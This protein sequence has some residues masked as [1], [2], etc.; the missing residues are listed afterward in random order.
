[1]ASQLTEYER[2]RLE[3]IKRN[4][5][6]MA[7]LKIQSR[8]SELSSTKRKRAE[9]SKSYK[10]NP[11]KKEE[12]VVIRRSLRTRGM[13]P[14]SKGL[15]AD[16][17][18]SSIKISKPVYTPISS[19]RV[20]GPLRFRDSCSHDSKSDVE[21]FT[22]SILSI[23]NGSSIGE[24]SGAGIRNMKSSRQGKSDSNSCKFELESLSLEPE[25]IARVVPGRVF[26]VKFFPTHD[27]EMIAVGNKFGNVGFWNMKTEDEDNSIHLFRLH[28]AP[29]SG[30]LI[31]PFS[32]SKVHTSCYDGM[33]RAMDIEKQVFDLVYSTDVAIYSLAQKL[34]DVNSIYMGEGLDGVV[35][36][37]D[38]RMGKTLSS[39]NLHGNRINSIDFNSSNTM[40]MAT[41]ST[42]G[43]AC[44]WD[45]R[46]MSAE[47]S[48]V[49]REIEHKR[50][51]HSAYFSPSGIHLATTS[52]DDTIGVS[53]GK[54]FEDTSMI[55]H[56]NQTGRWL[57]KFRAIWG[58]DDEHLYAGNMSRGVDVVSVSNKK[59]IHTMRSDH[60]TAIPCR[61]DA[62]PCKAGALAG[63]TAGGQLE[64]AKPTV[65]AKSVK[66]PLN[67]YSRNL[68]AIMPSRRNFC[69]TFLRKLYPSNLEC[70][71]SYDRLRLDPR[72]PNCRLLTTHDDYSVM[73]K[74]PKER[75]SVVSILRNPLDRVFSTYEFSIEVAARFLVHPN[76]TSATR[77]SGRIRKKPNA[78]STLDIW[79]WKYLVPWMREDLFSRDSIVLEKVVAL[80]FAQRDMRRRGQLNHKRGN[81]SYDMEDMAM[82]LEEFI[83][84]SVSSDIIHNG[85]TFQRRLDHM[86]YV[87]LTEDHKG[88]AKSNSFANSDPEN[89][90]NQSS[91]TEHQSNDFSSPEISE[92]T[93]V[94]EL[95]EAYETCIAD[96]W[97]SQSVRR[98]RSLTRI[99]PVNFTKKARVKVPESTL[100]KIRTLNWLD[101]ELYKYAQGIASRQHDLFKHKLVRQDSILIS[102]YGAPTWEIPLMALAF[103]LFASL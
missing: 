35:N 70:P 72:K 83:T 78:V 55:R 57:S 71:R 11:V 58:W 63:A 74:L 61:F 82:P 27:L 36:M 87:G 98:S 38:E 51:V 88:S 29:I 56:D 77:M 8:L 75:T 100:Q 52:I 86:L 54:N 34:D 67:Q 48:V 39:W 84:H 28:S 19:P 22:K 14:D 20:L 68:L 2:L 37:W 85:A 97:K 90:H 59:T 7:S 102:S 49:L 25:N 69:S 6:L 4:G 23:S 60:M 17:L 99:H 94:G 3:N 15:S 33:V 101:V 1:M 62:H 81:D 73:S 45:L 95:M 50:A 10:I 13:A 32:K 43:T 79:P 26:V 9:K 5:E 53:S 92:V 21:A 24:E 80:N 91:P 93:S 42:D 65:N 30:I 89:D 96:L 12:P 31:H 16:F 103:A 64:R 66:A 41:S 76:L 47:K 40:I 18:E 44:I 46:K